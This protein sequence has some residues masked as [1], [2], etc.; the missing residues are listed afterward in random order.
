MSKEHLPH[1]NFDEFRDLGNCTFIEEKNDVVAI[2]P[3]GRGKTH[4]ALA[5]GYEAV[6]RGYSVRFKRA[7]ELVNEMTES[8]SDKHLVDYIRTLNR[9]QLLVID[10]V[11]Y[12]N[13]DVNSSSLLFQVVSARYEKAS[14]LYTTNLEFSKWP[15]FIGDEM[16]ASAIIDRIAHHAIILNMNGPKGWRLEHARSKQQHGC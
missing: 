4:A 3:S 9:C 15:Q 5:I 8:R 2:G 6:K 13:Y 1:L 16:L 14:T 10:E 11:G 12:L 7:S